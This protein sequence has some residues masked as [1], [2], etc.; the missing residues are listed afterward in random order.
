[1]KYVFKLED[2]D[3]AHCA[4][5]MENAIKK[6]DGVENATVSFLAQKL[7]IECSEDM[8]SDI[9]IK[10]KAEIKKVDPDC[11]VIEK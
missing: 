6:L 3:C 7:T 10:A 1:M 8:I 9:I 11:C 5:R 4:S 2:L